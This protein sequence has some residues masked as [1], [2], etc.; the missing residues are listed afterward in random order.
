MKARRIVAPVVA[1]F[2]LVASTTGAAGT[3]HA[4]A[5]P[6]VQMR[7]EQ[8]RA[9]AL[10]VHAAHP[11]GTVGRLGARVLAAPTVTPTSCNKPTGVLCTEVDVPLDPS[12]V[13]PGTVPLH[14]EVLPATGVARGVM[15]LIAGG[16]GQGSAH[17]FGL[18]SQSEVS[19]DRFLFP[20]YTLVAYD[21]RG[22]GA[23]G[24][25]DCPAL[26]VA[27]TAD[28]QQSAAA[29][30]AEALG[31]PRDF[32]STAQHAEDLDA[33][34]QALG[35]DKVGLYGVSYG[36][37]LAL[38]YALAHPDHVERLLLDSVVQPD[39]SDSF[40]TNVLS[41]LP[42]TLAA[43]CSDGGCRAATANFPA[44]VAA[45][46]NKLAASPLQGKVNEPNGKTTTKRVDGLELLSI[47][48]DADLNPGLAA[49][50]PAV[51]KAA[52]V[53]NTQ[54]LLRLADL[55][56]TANADPSIDLSFALYAAT[57][58]RD[59]PFPW[60]PDTPIA[61]RPALEQAALAT[62]PAGS[63]GPFGSWAARF[64]NA[65]FCLHWP[66]PSG[67]AAL[68]AGPLPNVPVL[69]VSGGFDM[70]TPT[71]G[72]QAVISRFPQGQLVVVPGVG[73]STVNADFS[74]C[75][76][77]AVHAW[78]TGAAVAAHC[79][80]PKALVPPVP[81]LPAP[82]SARPSHPATPAATL[83]I[84]TKTVRE[85][86]AT[87]LMTAG[88]SGSTK[89]I[90]GVFGGRLAATSANT[91]KLVGYSVSRGVAVSGT[92]RISKSGPPLGFQGVVTV[93]GAAA[94]HGV[95]GLQAGALRGTLGGS[96][97]H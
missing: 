26:Q 52:R 86:E 75:A 71:A 23:S 15:F 90:P 17:V 36:T 12:G 13:V 57:V 93:A 85:A 5:A 58:C 30:C 25:L 16:P 2:A 88:L 50:L 60:T 44:D 24:L 42:A 61:G 56:D 62:L 33:V 31:P 55:H 48:L 27:L 77:Q 29:A 4:G 10:L 59:G 51:V 67:G 89:P 3:P 80:R 46:A 72:A 70:R 68:A 63:F 81:A 1:V 92:L 21:D 37:K 82:G 45:L 66:S 73:H 64:G 41:R 22:T 6:A 49:E 7:A 14:V 28:E 84:V 35:Y 65:D 39:L 97:F 69:A 79:A 32:Y 95:L 78:M 83:A 19:L 47:I 76:A 54:P 91:F 34:R 9:A 94:A 74:G 40:G 8:L 43:F 20:G 96:V 18:G 87:W 38:A 53:G 11:A